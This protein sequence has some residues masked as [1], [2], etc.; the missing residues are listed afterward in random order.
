MKSWAPPITASSASR[1]LVRPCGHSTGGD[2]C[3][4]AAVTEGTE[5][6]PTAA[7]PGA[8]PPAFGSRGKARDAT[9]RGGQGGGGLNWT[10]PRSPPPLLV[11]R[12]SR[13]KGAQRGLVEEHP[14]RCRAQTS[15]RGSHGD[16]WPFLPRGGTEPLDEPALPDFLAPS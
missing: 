13:N 11:G 15:Q 12:T 7:L 16:A 10:P 9:W 2:A 3:A 5:R 4:R 8:H 6:P 14:P 1:S